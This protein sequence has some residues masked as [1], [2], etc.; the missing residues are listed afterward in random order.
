MPETKYVRGETGLIAYQVFG[1]GPLDL[2]SLA[3]STGHID[4]RWESPA[5]ARFYKRLAS[6]ARVV[7]FDRRG[8]GASDPFPADEVPTW[9][10]WADDFRV[11]MDA[12][13]SSRAAIVA[14]LDAGP[15]GMMFAA[16][17]PD[18]TTALVLA[19]TS[20]RTLVAD[21][22]PE[23]LSP[24]AVEAILGAIEAGWGTE[25]FAEAASP[26]L[27]GDTRAR[28]WFAK[29]MRA[30]ASPRMVA[31]QLRPMMEL[32]LRD[33]LPSIRA[34]TL[35]LHR[36]EYALTPIAQGRYLAD[37]IPDARFVE[38]EG[39][40]SSL[41]YGDSDRALDAIEEFLTGVRRHA[42]LDRVLAT[43]LF[44][45]LVDSTGRAAELGDRRWRDLL[46]QHD[47]VAREEIEQNRGRLWKTTG[48]GVLAT[49][50]APGRAIRCAI[51]IGEA[52]GPMGLSMRA[53]LHAGEV[54]L[55][56][57]DVGGIAV[58]V[59]ARVAA[60]AG[61]GET[62]VSRTVADL[63]AGSDVRLADRGTHSLKG[64]PNEWQVFAVRA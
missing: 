11:V 23:G 46:D 60:L 40:D 44:T 13:G 1:E 8:N 24:E 33:V 42:P 30:S 45:D 29:Y 4:V 20:A 26:S 63:V 38:L 53:G 28:A 2:V 61:P 47:A 51:S 3:G 32:D 22:Y 58:H 6:F 35:V 49:F 52:L 56:E 41:T 14:H 7:L 21:D 39:A 16:T 50:D 5:F 18:R 9:E 36:R 25:A 19:N 54:E 48:D 10:E 34:P 64:V 57:N 43:V 12:A 31:A 15:M 59:A 55:R 37:H 17:H 27:A 62:L